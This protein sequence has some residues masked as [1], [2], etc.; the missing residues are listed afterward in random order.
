MCAVCEAV[1]IPGLSYPRLLA[2]LEG[3]LTSLLTSQTLI[4]LSG[5]TDPIDTVNSESRPLVS[6]FNDH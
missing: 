6:Y 5:C 4:S 1:G 3:L 2:H